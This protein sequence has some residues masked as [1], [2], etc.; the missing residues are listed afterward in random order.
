M[1]KEKPWPYGPVPKHLRLAEKIYDLAVI[2]DHGSSSGYIETLK[3]IKAAIDQEI[4]LSL[5]MIKAVIDQAIAS[6]NTP[7]R[8]QIHDPAEEAGFS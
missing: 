4:A 1:S 6:A 8:P 2:D 3:M 7:S 5:E